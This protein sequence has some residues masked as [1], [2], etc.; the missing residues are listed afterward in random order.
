M[1]CQP[2]N[3]CS[4]HLTKK[5]KKTELK[6][7]RMILGVF[8]RLHDS[9]ILQCVAAEG[10]A[11]GRGGLGVTSGGAVTPGLGIEGQSKGQGSAELPGGAPESS[12]QGEKQHFNA[13]P[14][15]PHKHIN[16]SI[17]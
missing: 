15:A 16:I 1:I 10:P 17:R 8:S 7:K 2:R 14:S 12:T 3:P 11:R 13:S 6:E 9:V 4:I 5:G